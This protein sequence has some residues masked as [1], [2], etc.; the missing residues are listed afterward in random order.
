MNSSRFRC[1]TVL[2][3]CLSAIAAWAPTP[4]LHADEP[5]AT[6]AAMMRQAHEGRAEWRNFQGFEARIRCSAD[7]VTVEGSIS[8]DRDGKMKLSLP[9]DARFAW[10]NRPLDSLIGHRMASGEAIFDVE[11]ADND[12]NHPHGRLL[13]SLNP[14]DKSLWRVKEDVLTEVHRTGDD[15]RFII[16]IADVHR[17]P[18]GK[19]LP[20][21]FVV[22]T[23]E[24]PSG[25]IQSVRQVH[26][27]WLRVA[28]VDLP[29]SYLAISN[30]SDG[31]TSTQQIEMFDHHA[32]LSSAAR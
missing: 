13:R 4:L 10:V 14:K 24:T 5:A 20:R 30:R 12:A 15:S 7:G 26:Q 18:E 29:V 17:T 3:C 19:H 28:G 27:E 11:F 23:W 1:P 16:S 31:T 25:R 2:C 8:V 32:P 22:T 9:E 6:A 21:N